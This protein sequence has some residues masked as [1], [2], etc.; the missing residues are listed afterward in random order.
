MSCALHG[1]VLACATFHISRMPRES[2]P[3]R[4]TRH[5]RRGPPRPAAAEDSTVLGACRHE[6]ESNV[7]SFVEAV[8]AASLLRGGPR[9]IAACICLPHA[10]PHRVAPTSGQAA[11]RP[12]VL[13]RSRRSR[14]LHNCSPECSSAWRCCWQPAVGKP[15]V[16]MRPSCCCRLLLPL[17]WAAAAAASARAV[18]PL[19]SGCCS[20]RLPL[21]PPELAPTLHWQPLPLPLLPP[22]PPPALLLPSALL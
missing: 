8:D 6:S 18:S 3:P 5:A 11:V 21:K 20:L 1:S 22:P 19:L 12:S 16:G 17:G 14:R 4:S 15:A 13:R 10:R 7:L 2:L 9:S